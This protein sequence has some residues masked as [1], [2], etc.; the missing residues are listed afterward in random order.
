[1]L[2]MKSFNNFRLKMAAFAAVVL[3]CA[4]PAAVRAQVV[5]GSEENPIPIYNQEQ[6]EAFANCVNTAATFYFNRTEGICTKTNPGASNGFAINSGNANVH[7]KLMADIDLNPGKNV[8][9][10]DGDGTDLTPWTP[11]GI[12]GHTF[13]GQF[14][15]NYHI[16]SGV[17]I[18][19]PGEDNKGFFGMVVS[20]SCVKNLGVVNSYISGKGNVG[21]LVGSLTEASVIHCFVDATVVG[22]A[23]YVGGLVG[24]AIASTTP[25]VIDTS[26]AAGSV[27]SRS[28]HVGGVVGGTKNT[29]IRYCYSSAIVNY[30]A[31]N[32]IGGLLGYDDGAT[33]VENSFYDRQ[34]CPANTAYG[35]GKWTRDMV[36]ESWQVLG[37]NYWYAYP[38]SNDQYYPS[39]KGFNQSNYA[40]RLSTLPVILSGEQTMGDVR[41]NFELGGKNDG[42]SWASSDIYSA[43]VTTTAI[44]YI[45]VVKRQ[46]WFM[47]TAR[48][49]ELTHTITLYSTKSPLIGTEENP[50]T[51]DNQADLI[52]FRD[53]I[54]S[55]VAFIYKHYSI[56]A[57]GANTY[58]LQTTNITL[59][60]QN[61]A[62]SSSKI[63][64]DANTAFA[65]IYD[66]GG[67]E[68]QGLKVAKN[69]STVYDDMGLFGFVQYGT[70]KNLGVRV[71]EFYVKAR[72]GV[73]CGNLN[74][75]TISDCYVVPENSSV[76]LTFTGGN[77]GGIVG[78]AR[79]DTIRIINCH[80]ECNINIT[81]GSANGGI[82][83]HSQNC[84]ATYI[85]DCYNTG[86]IDTKTV[87]AAG[88]AGYLEGTSND[89]SEI[90]RCY[91]TG[92]INS[93][94]VRPNNTS[95]CY[96]GGILGRRY[97]NYTI[98]T[99][100]YNTGN[101]TSYTLMAG[102][103]SYSAN[104]VSYCWNSGDITIKDIGQL[105]NQWAC[106]IA[107]TTVTSSLNIGKITVE[108]GAEAYGVS[109]GI[110]YDCFN[111][112]EI[113]AASEW[114]AYPVGAS[115]DSRRCVNIGR[116][117]GTLNYANVGNGTCFYDVQLVVDI[118]S[119]H[120]STEKTTAQMLG[121]ALQTQLGAN[122]VYTEGMYPR[123]KGIEH[124]DVSIVAASPVRLATGQNVNSV[125]SN[126]NVNGCDSSVVWT[127]DGDLVTSISGCTANSSTA[128]V[129]A[130]PVA[131]A[132]VLTATRNG[133]SKIVRINSAVAAPTGA[134]EVE[135]LADLK[136]LRD[137]VNT[138][139]PFEYHSV[140]VPA[141]ALKTTFKQTATDIDLSTETNWEPIGTE[142]VP[143]QGVY[144]GD[145]HAISNLTQSAMT[146]GGLFG[147]T[148]L[149]KIQNLTLNNVNI[150]NIYCSVGAFVANAY[151][152]TIDHCY[153]SGS[154]TAASITNMTVNNMAGGFI[155]YSYL[156]YINNSENHCSVT[157]YLK[158]YVGGFVGKGQA[159]STQGAGN[160]LTY[161][162]NFGTIT[163]DGYVGG[164]SGYGMRIFDSYNAGEIVANSHASRI[165]GISAEYSQVTNS[166]NTGKI[167][168][169]QCAA[170]TSTYV[171]G[172]VGKNN[173][174]TGQAQVIHCYNTGI[175][176]AA[177]REYVG[178]LVGC[179][180]SYVSKSYN[181]NAVNSTGGYVGAIVGY[182]EATNANFTSNYYDNAFCQAGGANGVDVSG[183]AEGKTTA[184][185]TDGS[186]PSGF[187]AS[188]WT[189]SAGYYPRVVFLNELDASCASAAKLQLPA[190]EVAKAV[191]LNAVLATGGCS[192]NVSWGL[193][194]GNSIHF[195]NTECT[196]T[197][198][199]RGVV[200]VQ[201]SKGGVAYKS[202]KL[203][204]G[205]SANSPLVIKSKSE[206]IN[207]RNLVNAGVTFYYDMN[208]STYH[209]TDGGDYFAVTNQGA[210]LYFKLNCDVDL[211]D[212]V[213]IPIGL[214]EGG[215]H[216]KGFFNGD[217]HTVTGLKLTNDGGCQGLFGYLDNGS[218]SN[219]NIQKAKMTGTG[220]NRGFVCGISDAGTIDHCTSTSDTIIVSG[221]TN[222]GGI[223]GYSIGAISNCQSIN[224]TIYESDVNCIGGIC[225]RGRNGGVDD[226]IVKNLALTSNGKLVTPSSGSSYYQ[227][228]TGGVIGFVTNNRISNCKIQNSR[229]TFNARSSGGICGW[230]SLSN[231]TYCITD[232]CT[233]SATNIYIGGIVG[234]AA[235]YA[236]A[237]NPSGSKLYIRNCTSTGG[238]FTSTTNSIGGIAG[239]INTNSYS[240]IQGCANHTPITGKENVGGIVGSSGCYLDSCYN[241]APITGTSSVGGIA[242]T[243][244]SWTSY[245]YRCFNTG[246][247]TGTTNYTGG[248][249]GDNGR[250][251]ILFCFNSGK[252]IGKDYVG[253]IT[254]RDNASIRCCYNVGQVYGASFVGGLAGS[255]IQS[256][257]TGTTER[258]YN[259]AHVQGNSITGAIY[260]YVE[261]ETKV[262]K[263]FYDKQF[264]YSVGI[265]GS[266]VAGRADGKL[267]SEMLGTELKSIMAELYN[268][269]GTNL[270][271]WTYSDGLYPQLKF[272]RGKEWG[273]DA[274][275]VTA[276]PI[277]MNVD[278][279]SWTIP[280]EAPHPRV[281][282]AGSDT[283]VWR[284]LEG[285]YSLEVP[286]GVD[287]FNI[288]N[289]GVV[290]VA[291]AAHDSIYKRVRLIIGI[292]EESPVIIKNYTQ[293]CYFRDDINLNRKF[294]YDATDQSFWTDQNSSFSRIEIPAGGESMYF[295][296]DQSVNLGT[297]SGTWTPIGKRDTCAFKGHF[298]GN[299]KTITG[300]MVDNT[301]NDGKWHGFFGYSTGTIKDLT[302]A[303]ASVEG[304][305][306]TGALCGYNRGT[307]SHCVAIG[308][309]VSGTGSGTDSQYTGGLCGKSENGSITECYNTNVVSGNKYVGGIAGSIVGGIVSQC[310]NAAKISV[311]TTH[312][313]GIAG[314]NSSFLSDSY[315]T[316]I[317]SGTNYVGG[318][319]GQNAANQFNRV[320]SAGQVV[321]T[322]SGL[323][324]GGIAN[325]TEATY[326][327]QN[328]AFDVRMS[329]AYGAVGGLD[330]NNQ[331]K[332]TEQMKGTGLQS[333]LGNGSWTYVDS[334]YP[335][336]T[337]FVGEDASYVSTAPIFL[338]GAQTVLDVTS[339]FMVYN[340]NNVNWDFMTPPATPILN[341]DSVNLP[342]RGI[343]K[344]TNCGEVSLKIT[345]GTDPVS[346]RQIDLVV[347]NVSAGEYNDTTCGEAYYWTYNH[348]Y[349]EVS[350]DYIEP[351]EIGPG[352]NQITTMH[353]VVPEPLAIN[354][355]SGDVVCNG[356]D[357]GYA[358]PH[359]TGCFGTY[360]Y[361]WSKEGDDTF[362]STAAALSG[363]SPGTYY[364]TVTDATKTNC[365]VSASVVIDEP[366][367]LTVTNTTSDSHCYNDNDGEL[368]FDIAGGITPYSITWTT[369]SAGSAT[370]SLAGT[371]SMS[372][373]PD[374]NYNFVVKD[375]NNCEVSNPVEVADDETP[376]AITAYGIE[377]LYDGVEVD[378]YQYKL[379]I[380]DGEEEL[381]TAG[382]DKTLANGDVL[383]VT[384]SQTAG[385]T[386]AGE[387]ANNITA[388]S[389]KRGTEDVTCRY[390]VIR[391]NA[392]V[393]INKRNVT[394]TSK[395]AEK[396]WDGTELVNRDTTL[397]GDGFA[398]GEGVDITWDPDHS[399]QTDA[400]ASYNQ[401]IYTF[402]SAT[403]GDNYNI[404]PVFGLL[405]VTAE[406]TLVVTGV[407]LTKT[408]DGEPLQADYI[409]SGLK[410]GHHVEIGYAVGGNSVTRP[411]LTDAGTVTYGLLVGVFYDGTNADAASQYTSIQR[412]TGTLTINK[413]EITLTSNTASKTYDGTEL[414]DHTVT[415]SGDV[416]GV[417]ANNISDLSANAHDG[418][419]YV[420]VI[421]Y[422]PVPVPT[423]RISFT[424]G[425]GY[426]GNNFLITKN[427]G[428]LTITK[429][430]ATY[431]GATSTEPYTGAEQCLTTITTSGLLTGHTLEGVTYSACRT[432]A[433][434]TTGTFSNDPVVMNGATNVT[435][436]YALTPVAGALT[437]NGSDKA[438]VI[439]S[440]TMDDEYYDGTAHKKQE[441]TVTY[442]GTNIAAI[443][444]TDGKQF[445]LPTNDI[446]AIT[447]TNDGVTGVTNV[448]TT[449]LTNDFDYAFVPSEHA[450]NYQTP[451]TSK[452]RLNLLPREIII[453]SKS[454]TQSYTGG[455]IRKDEI[456][457][458]G[459]GFPSGQGVD[460]TATD[461]T[462]MDGVCVDV[463]T[464]PNKF[465]YHLNSS[466]NEDNYDIT[467]EFGT[468]TI[469][470]LTLTVTADNKSRTYGDANPTFTYTM[471]GFVPGENEASL[472]TA[473]KITGEPVLTTEAT[474]TTGIGSNYP[475]VIDEND[476]WAKNYNFYFVNGKMAITARQIH[477]SANPVTATYSGTTHTWQE[478]EYPHYTI[479]TASELRSGD[480][481]THVVIAGDARRAGVTTGG[482]QVTDITIM[483]GEVDVTA[484]Y[485][486]LYTAADITITKRPL[487]IVVADGTHK[488]DGNLHNEDALSAPI[489]SIDPSTS[490]AP[491]DSISTIEFTGGGTTVSST[492]YAVGVNMS[493]LHIEN[494]QLDHTINMA[495]SYD[496]E[497][498]QG[499]VT[500]TPNTTPIVIT[501][502]TASW[503]YD[504]D[505]HSKNEYTVTEDNVNVPAMEGTDGL[506]FKLSTNDIITIT[507]TFAGITNVS[508]NSA[509]NNVF[510]YDLV[511]ADQYEAVTTVK[512]TLSITP[513]ELTVTAKDKTRPFGQENPDFDASYDGFVNSEDESVL[514]GEPAFACEATNI[515]PIGDYDIVI[516][517]GTLA[518]TNGNYTFNFVDGTLT[519][520]SSPIVVTAIDSNWIY[521]GTTHRYAGFVVSVNGAEETVTPAHVGDAASTYTL[522][523]GDVMTV[524]FSNHVFNYDAEPTVNHISE[525]NF[526]RG[527]VNVNIDYP[528][529]TTHDGQLTI[530]PRP[531]KIVANDHNFVYDGSVQYDH[532]FTVT[533]TYT[534]A[535]IG[536]DALTAVVEGN[537][538]Y[539]SQAPVTNEVR[540]HAFTHGTAGNYAV[541]YQNGT[542]TM[543]TDGA[544][545]LAITAADG[546]WTYDGETHSNGTCT[547]VIND[548]DTH[549][550]TISDGMYTFPNGDVMTVS[551]TGSV[552]N[553]SDGNVNNVPAVVSIMHGTE[554]VSGRYDY[555][556]YY[557][558]GTLKVNPIASVTVN[559]TGRTN[560]V[561]YN[562]SAQS[563][564]GYDL[565]CENSLFD[566]ASVTGPTTDPT[567]SG[568]NAGTYNMSID[569]D[570]FSSS[571]A[572]FTTVTFNRVSDG[573][574]VIS[575]KDATI[576][577]NNESFTYDGA[578]HGA[579]AT[580]I[581]KEGFV[582]STDANSVE[583]SASGSITYPSQSPVAKTLTLTTGNDNY[584]I[585]LVPGQLTMTYGE[586]TE[587]E[588]TAASATWTYDGNAHD[589]SAMIVKVGSAAAEDVP[590]S[591]TYNLTTNGDVLT[592]V[593]NGTITHSAQSPIPNRIQSYTIL[594]NGN[595][596]SGKYHV[597]LR[598]G[599]LTVN[600]KAVTIT[601]ASRTEANGDAFIY[602]GTAHSD[603]TYTHTALVGSDVLTATVTG[604]VT[605]PGTPGTNTVSAF[606]ITTGYPTDYSITTVDGTLEVVWPATKTALTI[607]PSSA[608]KTYDGT[609]LTADSYTLTY[610]GNSYTVGADGYYTF[611]NSDPNAS[612][613]RLYVDIQ[614]SNTHV[615]TN[616]TNLNR[617]NGTP[618]VMNGTVDVTNAYDITATATG[619]L[620]INP[621]EVTIT[622]ANGTH[623]YDDNAFK[624]EEVT[625]VGFIGT[626]G[627][628]V[629]CTNFAS[630]TNPGTIENTFD[631]VAGT[632]PA[633]YIAHKMYGTL[634]V[635]EP[636]A[637]TV[638]I[639]GNS[640]TYTYNGTERTVT[641]YTYTSSNPGLYTDANF[642]YSGDDSHKTVTAMVAGT[643]TMELSAADF[644]N[645]NPA[646]NVTFVVTPGTL[647]INPITTPIV[648][649]AGSDSREYN[650]EALTKNS[651]T[652]TEDVLLDGDVLTAT[653]QGSRTDVGQAPN[654]VAT[655]QVMHG[656]TDVTN[657]YTFGNRI[658]GVLT[659]TKRN[660]TLT[661]AT[662]SKT[663]DATALT[664][665]D[666]TVGGSGFATGEG[667]AYTVTGTQTVVGSSA[668]TF[669]YTLNSGTVA[670]NYNI[671]TTN[672]TLT[673]NQMT[674]IKVKITG[675]TDSKAY[676]GT[677]QSVSG[678]TVAYEGNTGNLYTDADFTFN[679]T[680]V[681][682]GTHAGDYSMGLLATQF[683]NNND[684]F[685]VTFEIVSDGKMT[686][687]QVTE[688]VTVTIVGNNLT[689][690][691]DGNA[692]TVEGYTVTT[693]NALYTED[694]FSCSNIARVTRTDAGTTNMELAETDFANTSS[695]FSGT[696]TFSVTDGY[697]TI[698][699][700]P[701]A[702][703]LTCPTATTRVYNGEA[704]AAP[705]AICNVAA[706]T[707]QYSIDNGTTW[708]ADIPSITHVGTQVVKVK[709]T[710]T[711]YADATCEYT[712]EVTPA[713]LTVTAATRNFTYNGA[714][715]SLTNDDFTVSGLVTADASATYTA[716]VTGSITFPSDGSVAST[717]SG[718]T[719]TGASIADYDVNYVNGILTMT[720]SPTTLSLTTYGGTWTY[721]GT[722]HDTLQY[723]VTINGTTTDHLT[724]EF[725]L[726]NGHDKLRVY[727]NNASVTNVSE[728]EVSNTISLY[729]IYNGA[730]EVTG[731]YIVNT[732]I[733]K[734]KINPKN[735][736]ITAAD[737]SWDYDGEAH[738]DDS[739]EVTGLVSPNTLTAT[740]EG[741]ITSVGTEP[742]VV[743]NY[744]FTN[745]DLHN[746]TVTTQN[747]TLE[748]TAGPVVALAITANSNS[749]EYDGTAHS[750][751]GYSLSI[752]GGTAVAVTGSDTTFANGDVLTVTISGSVTNYSATA[753]P[754]VITNVKVM[755]GSEDVTSTY[756]S[757]SSR[758]NGE[759]II[760]KRPVT[761][762][763]TGHTVTDVYDGT[764]KTASDYDLAC[765]DAL[766]NTSTVSYS[767][768][769]S[770][771]STNVCD[772]P[773]SLVAD[774][775][776]TSDENFEASFTIETDGHLT[777]TKRAATVTATDQAFDYDGA[778]HNASATFTTTNVVAADES[779][780]SIEVSG[781]IQYPT[782]SPVTKHITA[783]NFTPAAL[784]DNYEITSVDGQLTMAFGER[785]ALDITS[786]NGEWT[787]DGGDHQKDGM[788]VAV[789]GGTAVE[790]DANVYDIPDHNG[791]RITIT[792]GTTVKDVTSGT[793][794]TI[795]SYTILNNGVDVSDKYNVLLHPGNLVVNPKAASITS[796]THSWPYDGYAH[797]DDS[798]TTSGLV[799]TDALTA[800]VTGTITTPG[801]IQNTIASYSM[802][803]GRA[804]N[805][806]FTLNHGTL[807]VTELTGDD[808]IALTL[809][810]NSVTKK[811]DGSALSADGFDMLFNGNSYG[812]DANGEYTF[813]NGDRLTV[814]I[815]GSN[816]HVSTNATNLNTVNSWSVSHNG[817][818][819]SA[820][821][822]VTTPTGNLT[823]T[824]RS[825]T[826]TSADD[827]KVYDGT[828]LTNDNVT[829]TGDG[830]IA[831]EG[832]TYTVTGTQTAVGTS[833]N[834]FT[835]EL[836]AATEADDYTV[837]T[838]VYGTLEVTARPITITAND[839]SVMYDGEVHNYAQNISDILAVEAAGTNRGLISGHVIADTT[840][841]GSGTDAGTYPIEI[842][843]AVIK[844]ATDAD[845]TSNY[846]ITF[847]PG[848]LTITP[849]TGVV[850]TIQEHGREVEWNGSTQSVSGYSV[851]INDPLY[852]ESYIAFTGNDVVSEVGDENYLRIYQMDLR[853]TDFSNNN[854]NFTDVTFNILD[855]ALYIYPKL[856]ASATTTDIYCHGGNNGTAMV[857]VTG[858]KANNGKYSFAI[859]GG[860]AAEFSSPHTFEGLSEGDYEV[861]VTDSLNYSVTV[862]FHV[863]ELPALTATIV[864]PTDL[865]PNQG[866]YPVSVTVNGGTTDY[867]YVWSGDATAANA[868]ATTVNQIG[869]ND[870]EQTYSVTVAV[871]DAHT[872]TATAST[873]FTVKPSVSKPGSITYTCAA[874]TTVT[875]RYGA[876]DT[877]IVLN[878]PTYAT[879][880]SLPMSVELSANGLR[881]RYAVPEGL[882]DTTYIVTWKLTDECGDD[883]VIC[884]QRVKVKYPACGSV[885][886]G[887]VTYQAVRLGGNCWTR[888][889]LTVVPAPLSRAQ[890]PNGTYK[891]NDDDALAAEYGYLYTWYAACHVTENDNSAVPTVSNGHVQ[892]ICPENW[893]LPTA[894]DFIYM[895][896]AIG[897]VPH[898]KIADD[899][900]WISGLEGTAP[901]SGFDALGAGYY[902][903]S[904]DSFEGLMTVARF[905]TATPSGSSVNGTAVQ[906]AICEGEDV[907]IAPK[908][909]GYSVRCVRVQ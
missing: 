572:N 535:L 791:D 594:N 103:T 856:K 618:V 157:G 95:E 390:N 1:M 486:P 177:N 63:G 836:T 487:K 591:N 795:A 70:I 141:G 237:M 299:G 114:S 573:Q 720:Y 97:N 553:V 863:N 128:A 259:A 24:T 884:T 696:V 90:I 406:G 525:V 176:D 881:T 382:D 476:L 351:V 730:H 236:G 115:K 223:C 266:E 25:S 138:G 483:N 889:N 756:Y 878:Q 867:S 608:S 252:V 254:G 106:G 760:T 321:G 215:K 847:E 81:A 721:D 905:W 251:H 497:V 585:T 378:P 662:D 397:S 17:Y 498:V 633:D 530:T 336:L 896:E 880:F 75:G 750:D 451:T 759:L 168:V 872:C 709:A 744:N 770:V 401:F 57:R 727:F 129:A 555:A 676:N 753:T 908:A 29:R 813:E 446:I 175:I 777:I 729:T 452:G 653:I 347:Q 178:G 500:I 657:C 494:D 113:Y 427:E 541:S 603:A 99:H 598:D 624:K 891:Y 623:D 749:W 145:G 143:F 763:V 139:A 174:N 137:G 69:G 453:R 522:A 250:Y 678:Y 328:S 673:V 906:C 827:T 909:D 707:I 526:T 769:A 658:D 781:S 357:D 309:T 37:D 783:V 560:E 834:T 722:A 775:F 866:S 5:D 42:F 848:T 875:L 258:S 812:I 155:G 144:N 355:E 793:T 296:L 360:T 238:S 470:P 319:V 60:D 830:F 893:A 424:P 26:Y 393:R 126:F 680:A 480:E 849:R 267:T 31:P 300:M 871:T 899:N 246:A 120:N 181:A 615:A 210:D 377:K 656:T 869:T 448:L 675:N 547:L 703:T 51:I 694:C 842:T 904:S 665:D 245:M 890:S 764:E 117:Y 294:Y 762:S 471:T 16:I 647:T 20:N 737:H 611:E 778:V 731:N 489:Y 628:A 30:T 549:P 792:L 179:T 609:P 426:N 503:P 683:V 160:K 340:K 723:G 797:S 386:N 94:Y 173:W 704:F 162:S 663:Y 52:A 858:G 367:K 822:V 369:P 225:G 474:V 11:I 491:T 841:T 204:A 396:P 373:L 590:N 55:G 422:T 545:K 219:V 607:T 275:V 862:T 705:A 419:S 195:N 820:N 218:I 224:D 507:P 745:G 700:D 854:S 164:L 796:A 821:Y 529:V 473:N 268:L 646:F 18:N 169:A 110:A 366:T 627:D 784:A 810:P 475:I 559:I 513:V 692:Y 437:I 13:C 320:Y 879:N 43:E 200:F 132:T 597:T 855:S 686:I 442:G 330:P 779:A 127:K 613:D 521:D 766:F 152:D 344:V 376:Y 271:S 288:K 462:Q 789:A 289:A 463:G 664:N 450:T 4:A 421:D 732:T 433:G 652:N 48:Y 329:P 133:I 170:G 331:T 776:S 583:V 280:S 666:I 202:I 429:K 372:G 715:Q 283:T 606:A 293:L 565:A 748:V 444:G 191:S 768:T 548:D 146:Y 314:Y 691:Y 304:V 620:T 817:V 563:V 76:K 33:V 435:A 726:P 19:K 82:I 554:N 23:R 586:Q 9:G 859:N 882:E 902:K 804:D 342:Y 425:T 163:G 263:N 758:T 408:Y 409:V 322:G 165:G 272:I 510:T 481:I 719:L 443:E 222:I 189:L 873:T 755:R 735:V 93:T 506:K 34:M 324:I 134:L 297:Y 632:L 15:G 550:V 808:R 825:I 118:Y 384:V 447:P 273:K 788:S 669:S 428:T 102:I 599:A 227:S 365:T 21:G 255:K 888:A 579:T 782:Q 337:V 80:N 519:V 49:G 67:N 650:G 285:A 454:W 885:E 724:S 907:L 248:I 209:A 638:T 803:P 892:G 575:K 349:Y 876:V 158:S 794:N 156:S 539:P 335:Q 612:R 270:D 852:L 359:V 32:Q 84:P 617:V 346:L 7:Y 578:S 864:T 166:F 281:V 121:T 562:G 569:V 432:D 712:L 809:T 831:G 315:N 305:E 894:E 518:A 151:H 853:S 172:I 467:Q 740:V 278:L 208:D 109:T 171:G 543:H 59:P 682:A 846:D 353:L 629:E 400:G 517:Q 190:G 844:D 216:F 466:T 670:D 61:W 8:A 244:I 527:G 316:G 199:N 85:I 388:L 780:I 742:N 123:I 140:L 274:S 66:G 196:D 819:V 436:N 492:P 260:G 264:S 592:V 262:S 72:S 741:T 815:Q 298:N 667:A 430:A 125:S 714:E 399:S 538:Q 900:F 221:G 387:Y 364:V 440:A 64:K 87:Y 566:M 642:H 616:G 310:F 514:S 877:A 445:K 265:G 771:S 701:L 403:N 850:V 857:T 325:A 348:R 28:D 886:L 576:T 757:T 465:V 533:S 136:A 241:T 897:G 53:G 681:A 89:R 531:I 398:A 860:T 96:T 838:P 564:S 434:T 350:G 595:D 71:K 631:I 153:N 256:I 601:A 805:Y 751:N 184:E 699:Q 478:S 150:S 180:Y 286:S 111:A 644:T 626:D 702:M 302:I 358:N 811:Y 230:D 54:N 291:A 105:N 567:A 509:N 829:V 697:V 477:I 249:I 685:G 307:I 415:I 211:S 490:L 874:D 226:C 824:P 524:N 743:S 290:E 587:L 551:V 528:D 327:P 381:L 636:G 826:M 710:H 738:S 713:T 192:D 469:T 898:M 472:R 391:N 835:Y 536:S 799:G 736:T 27:S 843:A 901:S 438:I 284:V 197:V 534:P 101:L 354:M 220:N 625:K 332:Y 640:N 610:G 458:A 706:A 765:E 773:M 546:T 45:V 159:N 98:I 515:S 502:A 540:S 405:T 684:N 269:S 380:G 767:G 10:C 868:N 313:G 374:G 375:A 496:I 242:G 306:Y 752:D 431:T 600:Q 92:D 261:D 91:N 362:S 520:S 558:N 412:N 501:S 870:G 317:I 206:L 379:K 828:A 441:Y 747:G 725:T 580:E 73:I 182:N 688:D 203:N 356:N 323:Q 711:N 537:I 630:I 303:E 806:T 672:G 461:W 574:L 287:T 596:V 488:Y 851:N 634:T 734:L 833:D 571:D 112:G 62:V 883:T 411:T 295:R 542:L 839:Y 100:C 389:I 38:S 205:V 593:Y 604:S 12:S 68:I 154:I 148:R 493:T 44:K 410:S 754:N 394:I 74:G 334:L 643:H 108:R 217:N 581:T 689:R 903:S 816:T 343:V 568:T 301:D 213:W 468:I 363:M 161:C 47:L 58:F 212:A 582:N 459:M 823:I 239:Y 187:T 233:I 739:Y 370:Q 312:C 716:T 861:V 845:V 2:E 695:D 661:S 86:N 345:K 584:N 840:M 484:N 122:W 693:S 279:T 671:T 508:Q 807:T 395:S 420:T 50:F 654:Q 339:P 660:V 243:A 556:D 41:E 772:I 404:S 149:S 194:S 504:G 761:V 499:G 677:E 505:S 439:T 228:Y 717:V 240:N 651:F 774:N 786:L 622:S 6:L 185:L 352:C 124:E 570:D 167:T 557:V 14:D 460:A 414:Y 207:F 588:I 368:S 417:F 116:T 790:T 292:S 837:A 708:T 818:N 801:S 39:L 655:Y 645:D 413:R 56:P 698:T 482:V 621:R 456:T 36:E 485:E 532:G 247:I 802:A 516:T 318:V 282:H 130:S 276:T 229:L 277:L 3:M 371:Y 46:G 798:Y 832:A 511:N 787:Y 668:N 338:L 635:N 88:I 407:T 679:G 40:V 232:N 648:I 131:G 659:V 235:C 231:I 253:G 637:V 641:G 423:N 78:N 602:D 234:Q 785:V 135:D 385:L 718:L 589:T 198:V 674:G 887:G 728:G 639:T 104:E 107:N 552:T 361:Q 614:G 311:S 619:T 457:V 383:S 183:K 147:Y 561:T 193:E 449:A 35:E 577:A 512:G 495:S 418:T 865:C 733:G 814:D 392:F 687:T 308:G 257:Y 326:F 800:M 895:V 341:L 479:P 333:V 690:V 523:N 214:N 188:N 544:T 649:T 119:K 201:A 455:E 605:Y 79:Y 464:Y 402:T 65:G 77:D 186:L 83:G 22:Q 416:N 142:A 746:Y